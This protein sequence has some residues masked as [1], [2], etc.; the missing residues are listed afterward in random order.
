MTLFLSENFEFIGAL[1]FF[2]G[3]MHE[4]AAARLTGMVFKVM[5]K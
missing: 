3:D 2:S 4:D 5:M 1:G